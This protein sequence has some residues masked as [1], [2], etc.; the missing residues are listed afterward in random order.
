MESI[1]VGKKIVK[2]LADADILKGKIFPLVA[3]EGAN[4]PFAVYRRISTSETNS[5][6]LVTI[7]QEAIIEIVIASDNYEEA[8]DIADKVSE[9]LL[10]KKNIKFVDSSEDFTDDVFTQSL[11]FKILI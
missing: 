9:T 2:I 5:K 6:D 3:D 7:G 11:T 10:V 1:K 8:L 4:F